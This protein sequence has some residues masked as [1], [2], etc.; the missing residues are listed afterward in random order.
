MMNVKY[1]LTPVGFEGWQKVFETRVTK[2]DIPVYVYQNPEVLPRIYFAESAR[3]MLS[4]VSQTSPKALEEL[5]KIKDFRF[6]T[7][8]ECPTND[9][10][11]LY[12]DKKQNSSPSDSLVVRELRPG[13]L[14]LKTNTKSPR[15]LIYSESNLPTWEARFRR[16]SSGEWRMAAP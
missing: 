14:R 4:D 16:S 1:I 12:S 6:E 11:C 5:F 10:L 3:T 7:L 2:H 8:I 9:I 13:Y 15:W